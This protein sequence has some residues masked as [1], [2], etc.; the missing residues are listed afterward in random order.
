MQSTVWVSNSL[1]GFG[2]YLRGPFAKSFFVTDQLTGTKQK[3]IVPDFTK[4]QLNG[5]VVSMLRSGQM[6]MI[7]VPGL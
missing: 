1:W 7:E 5:I 6:E 4:V 2:T 3:L